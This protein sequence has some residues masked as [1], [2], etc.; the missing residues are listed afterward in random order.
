M[1]IMAVVMKA[2]GHVYYGYCDEGPCLFVCV[3]A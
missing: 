3:E 2:L 1:F